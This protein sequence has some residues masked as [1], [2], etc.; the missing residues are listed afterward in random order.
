MRLILA[1]HLCSALFATISVAVDVQPRP[2]KVCYDGYKVFRVSVGEDVARVHDVISHLGLT[3]WKGS[4]SSGVFADIVVPPAQLAAFT[5]EVAG[6]D[7]SI[8][9]E[10]LGASIAEESAFHAYA[11]MLPRSSPRSILRD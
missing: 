2:A 1:L 10:D 11:S 8:M 9:H 3:T 5:K 6:L 4:P 7:V